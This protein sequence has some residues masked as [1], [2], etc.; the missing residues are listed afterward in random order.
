MAMPKLAD[1]T[2]TVMTVEKLKPRDE[3]Y[4]VYDAA[5]RG[6]GVRVATSGTK[7][8][9]VMRR[10]DGR[11]VR[12][13]VGRYP[14]MTLGDARVKG[15]RMLREMASGGLPGNGEAK[16]FQDVLHEWLDRD[17]GGNRS[18]RTVEN[19]LRNHALPRLRGKRIDAIRKTDIIHILDALID[20]GASVQANRV[21]SYLRRMFNWSLERD[22]VQVNPVAGIKPPTRERTADRVLSH[23]ELQAAWEGAE[24]MGYPFGPFIQL[25]ILTG[26][27]RD[28]V[29]SMTW[30]EVD[31][32]A[33]V[34]TIP[35][36]RTKNGRPHLVHLSVAAREI[37]A[38][39]PR[40][41][42]TSLLFTTTGKRSISGFSKGK[43]RLDEFCGVRGWTFHDLR[44]SFATHLTEALG[45]SPVVVDRILNHVS[46][47]VKGVA[48]VYQRGEYLS[49]RGEALDRWAEFIQEVVANE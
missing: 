29:A 35:G 13:S 9:F 33:G 20:A 27:R 34:W 22:L 45:F 25:L 37:I 44:R 36:Q 21:L 28:E 5:L 2:L 23:L 7:T 31:L 32:D 10:V 11:M 26:Q 19:A 43:R 3:R 16:K 38:P 1:K 46:G 30:S 42:G 6:F 18:R 15:E 14:E 8:W 47:S 4:D 41:D 12:A 17:Q 24:R 48:A 49:E 40:R 39:L